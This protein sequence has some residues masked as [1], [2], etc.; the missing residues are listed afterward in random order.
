M[1]YRSV[2]AG[3]SSLYDVRSYFTHATLDTFRTNTYLHTSKNNAPIRLLD[4][5]APD[6]RRAYPAFIF[7]RFSENGE[8]LFTGEEKDITLTS[9]ITFETKRKQQ[10][11]NLFVKMNPKQMQ[12]RE[13]FQF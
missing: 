8:R 5:W 6:A 2:P 3:D 1:G 7:P 11:F 9:Q 10:T 12:F 4:Y 13:R